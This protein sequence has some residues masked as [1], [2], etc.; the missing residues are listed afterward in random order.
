MTVEYSQDD[1][2]EHIANGKSLV[3]WCKL[4]GIG[5]STIMAHLAKDAEFQEKYTRARE[6]QADYLVD[7][8]IEIADEAPTEAIIGESVV[9]YDATAIAR[10]RLRV[11]TRKWA[12]SKMKPK[13]YG[14]KLDL[15]HAGAIKSERE[16]TEADRA[17]IDLAIDHKINGGKDGETT[18]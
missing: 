3:S 15:T 1:L 11:D 16:L 10:N 8:I 6:D 18:S 5:Y 2:C 14:E 4:T 9:K 7:E 13:K 17:L 12:A